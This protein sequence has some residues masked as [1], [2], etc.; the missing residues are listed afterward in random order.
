ML[1]PYISVIVYTSSV[2]VFKIPIYSQS[3]F[4]LKDLINFDFNH[5]IDYKKWSFTNICKLMNV[6]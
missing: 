4:W 2:A 1:N 6:N 5:Q 3:D